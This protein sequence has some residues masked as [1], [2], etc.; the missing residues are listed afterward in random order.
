MTNLI[1]KILIIKVSSL[2]FMFICFFQV[3]IKDT[4]SQLKQSRA[5]REE[6]KQ[7]TSWDG[8]SVSSKALTEDEGTSES[9]STRAKSLSRKG[10]RSRIHSDTS[11]DDSFNNKPKIK[12]E[13]YL[14]SDYDH[15]FTD[16]EEKHRINPSMNTNIIVNNVRIK[17][18]PRTSDD[19]ERMSYHLNHPVMSNNHERD[20]R[21]KS[22]KKKQKRQKNSLSSEDGIK[23]EIC[24]SDYK[25]CKTEFDSNVSHHIGGS[26][27]FGSNI[28]TSFNNSTLSENEEKMRQ[29]KKARSKK[30]KRRERN[31]E[32]KVKAR[33]KRL[34]RQE[35]RDNQ[36][37]EDIFGPLSDDL[38]EPTG[39][40]FY[41][42]DGYHSDSEGMHSP[43]VD[44]EQM[45]RKS[46]K[47]NRHQP[48]E[49]NSLDLAEAGR[50][51]EAKLLGCS[52]NS[53]KSD[54]ISNV[55]R[56]H[57]VFRFTDDNDSVEPSIPSNT[58]G[59]EKTKEK[60]K[61]RKKSKDE[62][63]RKE[64]HHHRYY[65]HN[66]EKTSGSLPDLIDDISP[67]RASSPLVATKP[68]SPGDRMPSPIPKIAAG[69][70]T[71]ISASEVVASVS[72][73]ATTSDV[74]SAKTE[75]KKDKFIPGFGVEIDESIHEN[76]VKSISEPDDRDTSMQSHNSR[77][78]TDV[79]EPTTPP[80]QNEEKPR[81]II[82]QEETEDAV[83]ALLGET[84]PEAEDYSYEGE[85]EEPEPESVPVD[86]TQ[87]TPSEDVEETQQAVNSLNASSVEA[88]TDLKPDT[89]QSEHDLQIDTD[90]EEDPSFDMS[91]GFDMNQP[92]K[93]PDI[94]SYCK[95]SPKSS[96]PTTEPSIINKSSFVDSSKKSVIS[97]S[98]SLGDQKLTKTDIEKPDLDICSS[99]QAQ[100]ASSPTLPVKASTCSPAVISDT[101]KT[102]PLPSQPLYQ[103]LPITPQNPMLPMR[104]VTSRPQQNIPVSA[105]A[106]INSPISRV[107]PT[108]PGQPSSRLPQSPLSPNGQWTHSSSSSNSLAL[109]SGKTSSQPIRI[110]VSVPISTHRSQ[111]QHVYSTAT[112]QQPVIQHAPGMR[113]VAPN[114]PRGGLPPLSLNIPQRPYPSSGLALSPIGSQQKVSREPNL[115]GKTAVEHPIEKAPKIDDLKLTPMVIPEPTVKTSTSPKVPSPNQP[116]TYIPETA[117]IE[118][119]STASSPDKPEITRKTSQQEISNVHLLATQVPQASSPSPVIV[120]H[121]HQQHL[122]HTSIVQSL[123]HPPSNQPLIKGHVPIVT[124]QI[125]SGSPLAEKCMV[126]S[127]IGSSAQGILLAK[128]HI[129]GVPSQNIDA[130]VVAAPVTTSVPSIIKANSLDNDMHYVSNKCDNKNEVPSQIHGSHLSISS[131][132]KTQVTNIK[133]EEKPEFGMHYLKQQP[134]EHPTSVKT[135]KQEIPLSGNLSV[136]QEEK[137]DE[138]VGLKSEK[139]SKTEPTEKLKSEVDLKNIDIKK[140]SEA[141]PDS[142]E[143]AQKEDRN[144]TTSGKENTI[145][146]KEDSDFWSKEVNIDSVIKK[147]DALCDGESND[148]DEGDENHDG[149]AESHETSKSD[150][151]SWIDSESIE[152]ESRKILSNLEDQDESQ[153]GEGESTKSRRGRSKTKR[154]AGNRGGVTTRRGGRNAAV[155]G[156]SPATGTTGG[157]P[158]RGGGRGGRGGKQ[159]AEKNKLP[160]D[161]YEFHDDS[162]EDNAGRPRLIITIK[163][164]GPAATS[165]NSQQPAPLA[166]AVKEESSEEFISPAAAAAA[167]AATNTRKSR[168]LAEKDGSRS[169]IDDVIED[170]VRGAANKNAAAAAAAAAA[171]GSFAGAPATRRSTRQNATA[172]KNVLT[173]QQQQVG[174][175]STQASTESRKSLR[176]GRKPARLISE[177]MDELTDEKLKEL[178]MEFKEEMAA[179]SLAHSEKSEG[180][181]PNLGINTLQKPNSLEPT[182]LIDPVTGLLTPMRE[183]E[184]GQY[185]PVS[186]ASGQQV[187]HVPL[188]V[189]SDNKIIKVSSAN[190]VGDIVRVQYSE[191]EIIKSESKVEVSSCKPSTVVSPT[192]AHSQNVHPV[193]IASAELSTPAPTV[194]TTAKPTSLK[195][196]V[197]SASKLVNQATHPTVTKPTVPAQLIVQSNAKQ[198]TV[199]QA[200]PPHATVARVASPI[201][202]PVPKAAI[203]GKP[204][205]PMSPVLANTGTPPNPKQHLLQAAKQQ[206]Q[207]ATVVNLQQKVPV[208]VHPGP[209]TPIPAQRIIT[210]QPTSLKSLN[211]QSHPLN[212]K[213]HLLQSVGPA[214]IGGPIPS[215]PTPHLVASPTVVPGAPCPRTTAPKP[216][217]I[218]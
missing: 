171:G 143:N 203:N 63:V 11:D 145:D 207:N 129:S 173:Q 19:D 151:D 187:I 114:Y 199:T 168:R 64:Y 50:E 179:A 148:H 84:F 61:K 13:R 182:S 35:A 172:P 161:V 102:T 72:D 133:I 201:L 45:R 85:E 217:V 14:E 38:D 110:P 33:R 191:P 212:P 153:E 193:S 26:P 107:G 88:E 162:E 127:V 43:E 177:S 198:T 154:G 188:M 157:P 29:E 42:N 152:D 180:I 135:E 56:D 92:P 25:N 164:P 24:D 209:I 31:S 6:K 192:T 159:H 108:L 54:I 195:A 16:L 74:E 30:D 213:A 59:T 90:T 119:R 36:R 93:T 163:S 66:Q 205:Q 167:A 147:V 142:A 75:K 9:D 83:A 70:T 103:R 58:A 125:P 21:K 124:Q 97:H 109:G 204:G 28:N 186:T 183:L 138:V 136:K 79:P 206:L 55:S 156:N 89:P 106:Q 96:N 134:P 211:G 47:K 81:V 190:A 65:K 194:T 2:I 91:Q 32:S 62:R 53:L 82:S 196:H 117:K 169:T 181:Q 98:W 27:E 67:P 170:V 78:D 101:I 122:V 86:T 20:P 202:N 71:A 200:L 60:K 128:P 149:N 150:G 140:E 116:P 17:D 146:T 130:R 23:S 185:I 113:A 73:T 77:E 184:E 174:S 155:A 210:P 76:A 144:A 69:T 178:S 95:S 160:A 189:S 44:Q 175:V 1:K 4:F 118:I 34:N 46:E 166:N 137:S 131:P 216:L 22:H 158:K 111:V 132:T 126:Q 105:H 15:E 40:T 104:P 52:P 218:I 8:D 141:K 57:D 37:M 18:E 51:I 115:P 87:E 39:N 112:G 68:T 94:P 208:N 176:T 12:R 48:V 80:V 5:R 197:L 10:S 165:P 99:A 139:E 49:E 41:N 3:R 121:G 123:M 215:P 214:I 100:K 120:A 7:S